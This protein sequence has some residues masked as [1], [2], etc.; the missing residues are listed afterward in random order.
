[1]PG[2]AVLTNCTS[3][4]RFDPAPR[5][6]ART[7]KRSDVRGLSR[8]WS[9]RRLDAER[10]PVH[11]LYLGRSFKI[12]QRAADRAGSSLYT[13]S[14]GYGLLEA[15][16]RIPSYSVTV[17]GES[18]DNV[19]TMAG[20]AKA[21]AWWRELDPLKSTVADLAGFAVVM[22]ALPA[23]YLL[24]I[25]EDLCGLKRS[26]RGELLI[27]ACPG[28]ANRLRPDLADSVLPYGNSLECADSPVRGTGTDAAQRRLLHF[29]THVAPQLA[30]C[31][32]HADAKRAVDTFARTLL[33]PTRKPGRAVSDREVVE[34]ISALASRGVTSWTAALRHLRSVEGMAC[35]QDRFQSLFR[36][37][38]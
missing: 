26:M 35:S 10:V 34:L 12:A 20:G 11:D 1:M 38:Q 15:D 30:P 6:M 36:S 19:L 32:S 25:E 5:Q 8:E 14:A 31:F 18:E 2:S 28:V 21:K 7:M 17:S 23:E 3:S 13:V 37:V 27:F 29:T 24:M 33:Q 16:D 4:K 9:A 22:I